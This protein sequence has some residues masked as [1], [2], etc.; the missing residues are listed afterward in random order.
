MR[1]PQAKTTLRLR[2]ICLAPPATNPS[3][4]EER[5]GLQDRNGHLDAGTTQLDGSVV[6]D[7]VVASRSRAGDPSPRF[8]GPFVHGPTSAA[9]LYLSVREP[10]SGTWVRRLKIPLGTITQRQV[11]RATS[12]EQG[13]LAAR[14]TGTGSGTVPLLDEGWSVDRTDT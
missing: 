9:F 10:H 11:E 8:S 4:G 3:D 14:I 1:S 2:V 13:Y 7:V 12:T 6:Y 5:C